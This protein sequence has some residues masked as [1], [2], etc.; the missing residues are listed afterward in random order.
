MKKNY[1]MYAAIVFIAYIIIFNK[2]KKE[3]Q[4]KAPQIRVMYPTKIEHWVAGQGKG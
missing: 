1:L 3:V 2:S 4:T